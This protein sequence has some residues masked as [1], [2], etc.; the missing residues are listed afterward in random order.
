MPPLFLILIDGAIVALVVLAGFAIARQIQ[1]GGVLR[2]R[3]GTPLD[4][5]TPLEP[6]TVV[7]AERPKNPVLAWIQR[8][9][10]SDPKERQTI[11]RD[12]ALAGF[13]SPSAP[14]IYV[15]VRFALAAGLPIG[16]LIFQHFANHPLTG[17][18]L[19]GATALLCGAG[20][21]APRAFIDNRVGAWRTK[22][23]NDFPDV[24]D[25]LVV[26]VEAGLGIAA[27]FIRVAEETVE[28]HPGVSAELMRVNQ[29][30]RVGRSRAE[31]LRGMADRTGVDMIVSFVALM[32]QTDALGGS[33]AQSLRT[34]S[35]EMRQTR[36]LRA[37]E[38][39]M[40][41][42]V[43]LT[44]PLVLC[45]LPVIVTAVMLPAIIGVMRGFGPK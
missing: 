5:G 1:A 19:F 35:A 12:L 40:R 15:V 20:L 37:E 29:D 26:T 8:A 25:L 42:P 14:A 21:I 41:I 27:G 34:Y 24:L 38:K 39:A 30:L 44:V 18:K 31:A 28:S 10:L 36:M 22:L 43:L 7:R 16:F 13:E 17:F 9:T 32:I 11:R 23:E 33:I 3:L 4:E 45:I 6:G 2:R